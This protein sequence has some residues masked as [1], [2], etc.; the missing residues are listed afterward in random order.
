[1]GVEAAL[2]HRGVEAVEFIGNGVG[3]GELVFSVDLCVDCGPFFRVSLAKVLLVKRLNAVEVDL[4]L[5]VV[6]GA[7]FLATLEEHVLQIMGNAGG[8]LGVVLGTSAN[9]DFGVEARFF[10]VLG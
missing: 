1:M 4:L 3:R 6:E 2:A 8:V 9:G 5:F 10:A 7:D